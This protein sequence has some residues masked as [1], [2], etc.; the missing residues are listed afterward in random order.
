MS[1]PHPQL[2]LDRMLHSASSEIVTSIIEEAS[3]SVLGLQLCLDGGI[4]FVE[5][6]FMVMPM[7]ASVGSLDDL[8]VK[9]K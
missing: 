3:I 5:G 9:G 4:S 6:Q 8:L 1:F 7:L 2:R